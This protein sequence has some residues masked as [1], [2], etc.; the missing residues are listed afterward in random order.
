MSSLTI[1]VNGKKIPLTEFPEEIITNTLLGMIQ[2][3]KGVEEIHTVE[4][5]I[6]CK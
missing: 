3:L 4:I 2:S 1:M 6:K 5:S